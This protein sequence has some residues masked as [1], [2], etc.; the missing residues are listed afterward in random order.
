MTPAQ[1]ATYIR[2]KTR[3]D[4]SV[5][6]D[7]EIMAIANLFKDEIAKKITD[8]NEGY[9]G[10]KGFRNLEAAKR[11]YAFE[12]Q[13]LNQMLY[14]EANLDGSQFKRMFE[15]NLNTLGI[16]TTEAD[17]VSAMAG[18][19]PGFMLF[20]GEILLLTDSA[21]IDVTDGLKLWY[22]VYPKDLSSLAGT[23]DMSVPPSTTEFGMPR[24]F[25]ELW[26]RRVVIEYKQ[27]QDKPIPLTE[28][29]LRYDADLDDALSA[30]KGQNLDRVTQP[31][32]PYDDGSE[33]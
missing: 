12:P 21:I 18:K 9:F 30:I 6:T 26:A 2:W 20:G 7:N 32:I 8:A 24:Q 3:T 13:I 19:D 28:K 15:Y 31:T 5:F 33:Y 14:L 10:I 11:N 23:T 4:S 29:E 17:I 27:S 16:V 1:F 22:M 25:H